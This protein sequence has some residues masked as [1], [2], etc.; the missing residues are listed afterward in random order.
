[1]SNIQAAVGLALSGSGW[2]TYIGWSREDLDFAMYKRADLFSD[3]KQKQF[4][5]V[6][7]ATGDWSVRGSKRTDAPIRIAGNLDQIVDVA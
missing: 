6:D 2:F 5:F 3:G 7:K 4:L 1:M